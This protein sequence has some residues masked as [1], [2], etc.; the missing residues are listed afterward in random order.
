[1]KSNAV[2]CAFVAIRCGYIGTPDL[3]FGALTRPFKREA[4]SLL[5]LS[6]DH[7]FYIQ[8]GFFHYIRK[9]IRWV[10]LSTI[11]PLVR[12]IRYLSQEDTILSYLTNIARPPAMTCQ[13][14]HHLSFEHRMTC[15]ED[16]QRHD[17]IT[18]ICSFSKT[19]INRA[20]RR[21][22]CMQ[23]LVVI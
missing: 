16:S 2:L 9:D 10:C 7:I 18:T 23:A 13:T 3:T 22:I 4:E 1:V 11:I 8:A 17:Q 12:R 19:A 21:I 20:W 6:V 15:G 14:P 5:H